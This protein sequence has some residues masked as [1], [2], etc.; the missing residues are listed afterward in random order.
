[1]QLRLFDPADLPAI[2]ALFQ[3]TVRR[4]NSRDYSLEQVKAWAPDEL[5]AERWHERLTKAVTLVAVLENGEVV[6]FGDLEANGH[7]DCL[8]THADHQGRGIG[9]LILAAL[10][11]HARALGLQRLFTE[12]SI[13]ARPFFEKH[14]FGVLAEQ[15]VE[16]RGVTFINY[17]ME[18]TRVAH[19]T[20]VL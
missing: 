20:F 14:G 5:N 19:D 12:A 13:T 7:I 9:G 18:K 17:R 3:G 1:M 2:L 6:G 15:Q 8:Y 4:V 11:E 10:E 16:L